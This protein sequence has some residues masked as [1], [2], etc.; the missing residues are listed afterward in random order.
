MQE[1]DWWK[2]AMLHC[3]VVSTSA[4][5]IANAGMLQECQHTGTLTRHSSYILPPPDLLKKKTKISSGP[6]SA[7]I[8]IR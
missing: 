3:R 2:V 1:I 4:G 5:D 6:S 7:Q 8:Q